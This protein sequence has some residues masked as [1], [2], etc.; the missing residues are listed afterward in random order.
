M[1][2]R[3]SWSR[4][5]S[6]ILKESSRIIRN[7]LNIC[8]TYHRFHEIKVQLFIGS[9]ILQS[10]TKFTAGAVKFSKGALKLHRA[11][12]LRSETLVPKQF[13]KLRLFFRFPLCSIIAKGRLSLCNSSSSIEETNLKSPTAYIYALRQAQVSGTHQAEIRAHRTSCT[14]ICIFRGTNNSCHKSVY[15]VGWVRFKT[16]AA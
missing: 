4:K 13:V 3:P 9:N 15:H 1:I 11:R 5:H 14:T 12:W 6:R 16:K 10:A 2:V 8:A 7:M